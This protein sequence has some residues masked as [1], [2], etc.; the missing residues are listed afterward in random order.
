MPFLLIGLVLAF[1]TMLLLG[2]T[3]LDRGLLLLLNGAGPPELV[4]AAALLD[5]AAAPLPLMI[6]A[7]IGAG[8]LL[9]HSGWRRA[10]PLAAAALGVQLL[11]LLFAGA[12][13]NLRPGPGEHVFTT[14][15]LAFPDAAAAHAAATAFALALLLTVRAPWRSLALFAAAAFALAAGAARLLLGLAW[16]SDVI[17]GW[18]LG[19]CWALLLLAIAGADLGDGTPRRLRHSPPKGEPHGKP[20]DRDGARD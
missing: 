17:G 10:L 7:G 20:Q 8:F 2:G 19:L 9:V 4:Q 18:A 5:R 15:N 13:L 14:Q 12:T 3:E 16:P 6:A 11:T 1:V